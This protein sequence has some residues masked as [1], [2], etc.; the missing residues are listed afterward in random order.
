MK[1]NAK[2]HFPPFSFKSEKTN[3]NERQGLTYFFHF[4]Y[5]VMDLPFASSIRSIAAYNASKNY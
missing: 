3:K 5:Y 2:I 1:I 4:L